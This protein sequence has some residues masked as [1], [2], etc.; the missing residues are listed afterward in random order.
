MMQPG[1]SVPKTAFHAAPAGTAPAKAAPAPVRHNLILEDRS[2]LTA[3]GIR[4]VVA[5]DEN[6][7]SVLTD[8]G[9]LVIGGRGLQVSELSC[10]SGEL[11]VSGDIE[12][13]QYEDKK[14]R[15]GGL[16]GRLTR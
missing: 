13:L 8:A 14:E 6:S 9:A 15:R 12:Y 11:R 2:R 7:V 5:Y 4:Q 16:L 3:T 10:Q 1:S